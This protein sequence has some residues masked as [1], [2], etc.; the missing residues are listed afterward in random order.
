MLSNGGN[1]STAQPGD[2]GRIVYNRS[3]LIIPKGSYNGG[4]YTVK[5][6]DTLFYIAR[7]SGID[8]RDLAEN[9]NITA[10]YSLNVGQ[11]IKFD[12]NSISGGRRD[13]NDGSSGVGTQP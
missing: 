5:R 9:N 8:F 6:G 7:I 3:Y 1:T 13:A 4:P 2:G 10:P 11:S 12:A